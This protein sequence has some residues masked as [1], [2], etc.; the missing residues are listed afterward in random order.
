MSEVAENPHNHDGETLYPAKIAH[1]TG[2]T[3]L[4]LG[5][6][7]FC[8]LI[9]RKEASYGIATL[10][11]TRVQVRGIIDLEPSAGYNQVAIKGTPGERTAI[12]DAWNLYPSSLVL[13]TDVQP[14]LLAAEKVKRATGITYKQ[15]GVSNTGISAEDLDALELPG[16]VHKNEKNEYDSINPTGVIPLLLNAIKELTSR[17]ENL[18]TIS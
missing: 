5:S 14:I 1:A 13:K 8:R 2:N 18:E 17:I 12:A 3:Y 15:D 11:A 7:W 9:L 4:Y 16:L 6:H 10:E